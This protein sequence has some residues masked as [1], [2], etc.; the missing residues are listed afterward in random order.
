MKPVKHDSVGRQV[1][2]DTKAGK[3]AMY[4]HRRVFRQPCQTQ[5]C[6]DM[7]F[8][9]RQRLSDKPMYL[10]AGCGKP[11]VR[12]C[13]RVMGRNPRDSTRSFAHC[14]RVIL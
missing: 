13:G 8:C 12:W 10:I 14:R 9:C 6:V 1:E 11:H 3:K 4:D 5:P 7:A 2:G